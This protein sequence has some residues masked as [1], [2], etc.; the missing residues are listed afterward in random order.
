M[1]LVLILHYMFHCTPGSLDTRRLYHE[2]F[3]LV[4]HS[5]QEDIRSSTD[6][7]I[8][9]VGSRQIQANNENK[10]MT[11]KNKKIQSKILEHIHIDP[12]VRYRQLFRLTGLSNGSLS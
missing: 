4:K 9:Q 1:L 10:E 6:S 2:R 7:S 11:T 8:I 12:G 5:L 3:R